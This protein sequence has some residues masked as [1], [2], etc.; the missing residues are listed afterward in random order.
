M[1]E[2]EFGK[3]GWVTDPEG[4]KVELWSRRRVGPRLTETSALDPGHRAGGD[5]PPA[6][7]PRTRDLTAPNTDVLARA[8][9]LVDSCRKAGV[10]VVLVNVAFSADEK[11]RLSQPADSPNPPASS[12]R[13]QRPRSRPRQ[14]ESDLRITKRQWG[15]S[16]APRW[17][18]SS[19]GAGSDHHPLRYRHQLRRRIDRRDAWERNYEPS[20]RRTRWRDDSW[21]TRVRRQDDLPPTRPDP[22]DRGHPRALPA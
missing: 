21:R 3:F 6:R 19:A 5:R 1:D 18:S 14:R 4:N 8:V 22:A 11:D 13:L 15:R 20:S 2:S 16:T 12:L 10:Q 7:D 17:T 9:K